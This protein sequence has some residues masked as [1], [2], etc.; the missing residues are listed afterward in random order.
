MG[1]DNFIGQSYRSNA[2]LT[3]A[4]LEFGKG[5]QMIVIN[6]KFTIM[7]TLEFKNRIELN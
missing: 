1:S 5:Y 7:R 6:K 2:V 4:E 3:C